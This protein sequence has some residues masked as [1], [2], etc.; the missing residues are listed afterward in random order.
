M[1]E[2]VKGGKIKM[3]RLCLLVVLVHGFREYSPELF[4]PITVG[5]WGG[6]RVRGWPDKA[7]R[8][9]VSWQQR[10]RGRW[11]LQHPLQG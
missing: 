5:L 11:G 8:L 6:I 4:S 7:A 9:S 2:E 1:P 10:E 3:E